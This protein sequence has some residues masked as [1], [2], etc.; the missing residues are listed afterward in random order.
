MWE[1]FA[2]S[3]YSRFGLFEGRTGRGTRG[4]GS[5]SSV[6]WNAFRYQRCHADAT[7]AALQRLSL[8]PTDEYIVLDIGCGA[9]AVGVAFGEAVRS[10]VIPAAPVRYVGFDHNPVAVALCKAIVGWPGLLPT[11]STVT[12]AADLQ[13]AV[14]NVPAPGRQRYVFITAAYLFAQ[15]GVESLLRPLA[16]SIAYLAHVHHGAVNVLNVNAALPSRQ[17]ADFCGMLRADASLA[18][19]DD[20]LTALTSPLRFPNLWWAEE[21]YAPPR[22]RSDNVAWGNLA[23]RPR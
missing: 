13:S 9:G 20:R 19:G 14:A 10:G 11:G 4:D 5:E 2:A 12:A 21:M 3:G 15:P 8:G 22:P 16:D 17:W 1:Q 18:L 7:S 23:V 6:L